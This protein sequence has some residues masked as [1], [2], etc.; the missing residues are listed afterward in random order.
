MSDFVDQQL[1]RAV[2]DPV[3]EGNIF[4]TPLPPPPKK[5]SHD[6]QCRNWVFIYSQVL[7]AAAVVTTSSIINLPLTPVYKMNFT[8]KTISN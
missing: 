7:N 3:F 5:I 4:G 8:R 2:A 6:L 1:Q